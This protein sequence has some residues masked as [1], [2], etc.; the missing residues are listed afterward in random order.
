MPDCIG[1]IVTIILRVLVNAGGRLPRR[2]ESNTNTSAR[3]APAI[4]EDEEKVE[5][6]NQIGYTLRFHVMR[7]VLEIRVS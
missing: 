6:R 2:S 3:S 1:E 7:G 5:K 4:G